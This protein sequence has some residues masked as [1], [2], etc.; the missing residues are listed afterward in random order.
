MEGR[1][2]DALDGGFLIEYFYDQG[3][4]KFDDLDES[5]PQL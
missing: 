3:D 2:L 4:T 5:K 1:N